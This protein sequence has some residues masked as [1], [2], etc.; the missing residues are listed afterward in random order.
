MQTGLWC[1]SSH[2]HTHILQASVHTVIKEMKPSA[3]KREDTSKR[4][5]MIT[6]TCLLFSAMSFLT[7]H[8]SYINFPFTY[9]VPPIV[10]EF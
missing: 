3:E 9:S 10:I 2:P 7:M 5:T 8:H 1:V 4:S 6:Q